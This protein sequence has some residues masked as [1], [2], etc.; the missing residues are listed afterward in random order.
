MCV[1]VC[2]C[3]CIYIYICTD[4]VKI[5]YININSF[6]EHCVDRS[7]LSSLRLWMVATEQLHAS[8]GLTL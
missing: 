3:V 8:T 5:L 4:A 7:V 6:P 2:V 1:C